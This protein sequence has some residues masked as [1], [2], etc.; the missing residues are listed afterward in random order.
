MNKCI[1]QRRARTALAPLRPQ[2]CQYASPTPSSFTASYGYDS[3]SR[4]GTVSGNGA[5]ISYGYV[6]NSPLI[7]NITAQQNGTTRLIVNRNYDHLNRLSSVS[8]APGGARASTQDYWYNEANQRVRM[9][10]EDGSFWVYEYD[11]LGQVKSGKR[12]WEDWTPAAGQQFEYGFDDI[13]NRT[14]TAV[15]GDANG[16][17]LRTAGYNTGVLNQYGTRSVPGALD[18]LGFADP[19][20]TVTANGQSTYRRNEYFQL[21]LAISNA[22][23]PVYQSI[24][25]S[26]VNGGSSSNITG[27]VLLPAA[28]E[29]YTHDLDGNLTADGLWTYTWDGANHIKAMESLSSVPA[30]ARRRLEFEYDYLE[31]RISK[32]VK[33]WDGS[34]YVWQSQSKYLYDGWNLVGEF[35]SNNSLIRS[36]QWGLDL[37]GSSEGAG[38]VGGLLWV[39]TASGVNYFPAYDGNGNVVEFIDASTGLS[40]AQFEYGPFGE[41][42]RA[43]SSITPAIPISWST[44]YSDLE[45]DLVLLR[46]PLLQPLHWAMAFQGPNRRESWS[47]S[48]WVRA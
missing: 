26:A 33:T 15:G 17:A 34:A 32:T 20:S 36:Y 7:G 23:S 10:R 47:E 28:G 45:T 30:Q 12:Y 24:T 46:P 40:A 38:G 37:S 8:A 27:N 4:L 18:M 42:I 13:G 44:K 21:P 43:T 9:N 3:A 41:V 19:A 31:R 35:D 29:V 39:T 5:T 14:V 25:V 6:A 2:I 22:S 48:L 11:G 1:F 16:T